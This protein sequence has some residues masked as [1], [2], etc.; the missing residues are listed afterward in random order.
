MKSDKQSESVG[1]KLKERLQVLSSP[2]ERYD[3][4]AVKHNDQF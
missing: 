4:S 1:Y 3:L 2:E